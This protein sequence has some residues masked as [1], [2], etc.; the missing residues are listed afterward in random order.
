MNSGIYIIRNLTTLDSY[1]GSS[2]NLGRRKNIHFAQLRKG[3]HSN[4]HLQ[5]SFNK[6]GEQSFEFIILENCDQHQL[7]IREQYYIDILIPTY[8]KRVIAAS[9]I[10]YKKSAEDI[11]KTVSKLRNV[12]RPQEVKD[13]IRKTLTGSIR[14]RNV[15]DRIAAKKLGKPNIA[16]FRQVVQLS[17]EG[18]MIEIWPSI[19]KASNQTKATIQSI[20]A[21]CKSKRKTANGFCW[22]YLDQFLSQL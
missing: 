16:L 10:G 12:P 19:T 20:S 1:V 11:E 21:V 5:N 14:P 22:M 6:H 8:N 4:K 7:L 3:T 9:N 15:V 17:K 13:K 2:G 18:E